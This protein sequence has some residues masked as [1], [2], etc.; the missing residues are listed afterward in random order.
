MPRR[1]VNINELRPESRLPAAAKSCI[2]TK[3]ARIKYISS[4]YFVGGCACIH[5]AIRVGDGQLLLLVYWLSRVRFRGPDPGP[6]A[7]SG[8]VIRW[9]HIHFISV[10]HFALEPHELE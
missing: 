2:N 7:R 8:L 1:V 6:A 5:Y 9:T 3:T 4:V 10:V